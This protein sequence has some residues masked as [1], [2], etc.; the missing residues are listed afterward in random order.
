MIQTIKPLA[1]SA[2]CPSDIEVGDPVVISGDLTVAAISAEADIRL[3]GSVEKHEDTKTS[4][5]VGT[6]FRERRDDRLAA[7]VFNNGPFYWDADGKA[8]M[9]VK[10]AVAAVTSTVEE[11][12]NIVTSNNDKIKLNINGGSPQTFTISPATPASIVGTEVQ[13]FNI[14]AGANKFSISVNGG[15][16]QDFTLTNATPASVTCSNAETYNIGDGT[17]DALKIK[18]GAGDSQTFTLTDGAARTAAQVVGDLAALV[19]A[20][21]SVATDKVKIT[22]DDAADAIEI[23]TVT[24]DCYTV[25]GLTV[26]VTNGTLRTAANIVTNLT[27]LAGATASVDTGAVKIT[28]AN[29]AHSLEILAIADDAYT[30][31]GFTEG[32]VEG[33]LITAADIAADMSAITGATV[34]DVD[35]YVV[36]T[37]EEDDDS[38][39]IEAVANDCYTTVGFTAGTTGGAPTYRAGSIAGVQ[40]KKPQPLVVYGGIP[41]PFVI[42]NNTNDALKIAIGA[43][44]DQTFDLT[45]GTRTATQVAADIN[46]TATGFEASAHGKY[47]RLAA[48]AAGNAIAV[49]TVA[50]PAAT[51]LGLTVTTNAAPMNIETLE[52]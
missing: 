51:T 9:Y 26:G 14:A 20:T 22:S 12:Y 45:A 41:G 27:A 34:A 16:A 39:E 44:E 46:A 13:N 3:I 11:P 4:C 43:G 50:N 37:A 8:A 52:Y 47:L 15:A 21:A 2:T 24:N 42:A 38:I 28:S 40:I 6:K 29:A 49:K 10:D 31:L 36:I 25:L 35:G 30:L 32:E 7:A 17:S 5:V 19:G 33:T 1:I 18:I 23:E 48:T